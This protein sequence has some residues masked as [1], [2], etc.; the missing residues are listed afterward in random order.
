MKNKKHLLSFCCLVIFAFFA[1]ASRV[2]KIH[3]GAF[4][5]SNRVEDPADTRNFIQMNDGSKIYG[6]KISWK[7][8]LLVK[9][10]IKID[11]QKFKLSEV[12]GY[13]QNRIYYGRLK[14]DYIQRIVHG[15]INV[16]VQFTQVTSTSTDHS[17]FSHTSTYT[18]TDHYSQRGENGPLVAFGSQKDIK[19]LVAG[20]PISEEMAEKSNHQIRK[21]VRNNRNYLNDI[22]EIYNNG[23]KPLSANEMERNK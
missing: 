16:Y 22:F 1:L 12:K 21:A 11:D 20:C 8:G 14:N 5:Y 17:G 19:E 18:R 3:L 9:D 13:Q 2:N 23:C 4:N 10:Q 15:K 6:E 7:S